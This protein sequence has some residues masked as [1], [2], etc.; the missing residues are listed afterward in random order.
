MRRIE[1]LVPP[2]FTL[3]RRFS[4]QERSNS[5]PLVLAVLH[6]GRLQDLVLRVLP[7]AALDHDP[8]LGVVAGARGRPVYSLRGLL[9]RRR[10]ARGRGCGAWGGAAVVRGAAG[11]AGAPPRYCSAGRRGERCGASAGFAGWQSCAR[12]SVSSACAASLTRRRS[13]RR[14]C[15]ASVLHDA[16]LSGRLSV[17]L[18]L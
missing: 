11:E 6:D 2:C 14:A 3:L 7:D 17:F 13:S 16:S 8:H 5:S 4:V 18:N 9:A 15:L 12:L 1:P 10:G